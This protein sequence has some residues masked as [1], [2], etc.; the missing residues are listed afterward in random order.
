MHDQMVTW[1]QNLRFCICSNAR[2]GKKEK[3]G[4]AIIKST[5]TGSR[6]VLITTPTHYTKKEKKKKEKETLM[7]IA[8]SV[9]DR[10]TR[11]KISDNQI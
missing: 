5:L 3:V 1:S 11:D 7:G 10:S 8:Y 4:R 6:L 2:V 9:S